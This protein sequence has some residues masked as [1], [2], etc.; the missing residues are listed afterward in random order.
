MKDDLNKK[1]RISIRK[2]AIWNVKVRIFYPALAY[3]R[4]LPS[5]LLSW[6]LKVVLN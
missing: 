5:E 4:I 2:G 3:T 6:K 1:Y